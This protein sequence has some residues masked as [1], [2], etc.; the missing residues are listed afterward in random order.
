VL[1]LSE[2]IHK[3]FIEVNEEGSEAAAVTGG[4]INHRPQPGPSPPEVLQFRADRPFAIFI[5]DK[6]NSITLFSG[7]V[8]RPL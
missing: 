4:I 2:V 8:N 7:V 3:T 6:Q 1:Y 5:R